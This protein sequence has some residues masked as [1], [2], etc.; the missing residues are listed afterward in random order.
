MVVQKKSNAQIHQ[1]YLPT[2]PAVALLPVSFLTV[3]ALIQRLQ[4]MLRSKFVRFLR[5]FVRQLWRELGGLVFAESML[6]HEAGE[7]GAVDPARHVVTRRNRQKGAS[8]VVETDG[9]VEARGF[10]GLLAESH[11]AFGAVVEP[12]R[13]PKLERRVVTRERRQFT[14]IAAL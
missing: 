2:A 13:R 11:H 7:E 12:P 5:E 10:G 1:R 4:W 9:V 14:R 6:R 8:V 3:D